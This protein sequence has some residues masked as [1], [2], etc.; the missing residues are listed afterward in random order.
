MMLL[1]SIVDELRA[2]ALA[3]GYINAHAIVTLDLV[4]YVLAK[5]SGESLEY[6]SAA[7]RLWYETSYLTKW[8][9]K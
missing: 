4:T 5:R 6:W 1:T 9:I 2:A 7:R 8:G 3:H